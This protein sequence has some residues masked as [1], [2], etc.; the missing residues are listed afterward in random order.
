MLARQ[1][2]HQF[3]CQPRLFAARDLARKEALRAHV[4]QLP[5]DQ[6]REF[7]LMALL[8]ID[9]RNSS[10]TDGLEPGTGENSHHLAG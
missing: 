10:V 3:E 7:V 9:G 5:I 2:K 1:P 4:D 6:Q 8:L